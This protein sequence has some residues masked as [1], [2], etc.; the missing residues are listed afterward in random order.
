MDDSPLDVASAY[1]DAWK[2]N[3]IERVRPLLHADVDF[4]G[5]L[6]KPTASRRHSAGWVAC[7]R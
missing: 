1:F 7:S 2:A 5:A 4:V 3:D 6:G